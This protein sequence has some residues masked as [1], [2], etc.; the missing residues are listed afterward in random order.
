[1]V[2]AGQPQGAAAAHAPPAGEDVHLRL[3]EHVAHVQAAGDVGRGQQDGKGLAGLAVQVYI[4]I[5]RSSGLIG[6]IGRGLDEEIFADP[7]TG[8][9]IFNGGW[10]VGFGQVVRH[11]FFGEPLKFAETPM[12]QG[13]SERGDHDSG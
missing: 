5:V 2:G 4:R 7:V 9:V 6:W 13:L 11:F 10:V 3:V 8:P 1:M 12:K